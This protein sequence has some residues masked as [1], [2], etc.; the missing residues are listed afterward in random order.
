[1]E[2]QTENASLVILDGGGV[3]VCPLG[4]KEKWM[5][6]RDAPGSAAPP[7]FSLTLS[8]LQAAAG[9][10]SPAAAFL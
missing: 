8:F 3:R 7:D 4:Q 6:G 5:L 1:M 9:M 10:Q 2:T